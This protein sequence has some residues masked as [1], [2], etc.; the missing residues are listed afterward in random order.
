MSRSFVLPAPRWRG[1]PVRALHLDIRPRGSKNAAPITT[2]H[3]P[4]PHP[5]PPARIRPAVPRPRN[6]GHAVPV[7]V[8]A[9]EPAARPVPVPPAAGT[10]SRVEELVAAAPPLTSG[11]RDKL[12][13]LLRTRLATHPAARPASR[14]RQA[15]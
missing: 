1:A 7:P 11:Q 15:A 12:A 3:T 6:P 14:G 10:G 5:A 9:R 2:T 13:L 8:P 4:A